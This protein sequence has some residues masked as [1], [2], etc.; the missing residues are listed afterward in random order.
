MRTHLEGLKRR[1]LS[2]KCRH[3]DIVCVDLALGSIQCI[4]VCLFP[5]GKFDFQLSSSGLELGIALNSRAGKVC[6]YQSIMIL[7][8]NSSRGLLRSLVNVSSLELVG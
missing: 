8:Q 2:V 6:T 1:Y 7:L 5:N 3:L 4:S